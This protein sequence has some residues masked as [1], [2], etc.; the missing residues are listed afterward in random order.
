MLLGNSFDAYRRGILSRLLESVIS[1]S[2]KSLIQKPVYDF[3]SKFGPNE[4]L[5][6]DSS[7]WYVATARWIWTMAPLV[8]VN[9][10]ALLLSYPLMVFN[11]L[12]CIPGVRS[13][14][15]LNHFIL[16]LIH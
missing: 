11:T 2:A 7:P 15:S 8:L 6:A 16:S 5:T 3:F 12:A 1:T 9:Q 14:F 4:I 13:L 10:T